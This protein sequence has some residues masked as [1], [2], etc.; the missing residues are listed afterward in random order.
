LCW[1]L[2]KG[3]A[4]VHL[5][6]YRV[7]LEADQFDQ[8]RRIL[9]RAGI[10]SPMT[11]QTLS[12]AVAATMSTYRSENVK[13]A[14]AMTFRE[15]HDSLRSL[16]RLAEEPDPPVGQIRALFRE[17][18]PEIRAEIEERAER[19]WPVYLGEPAPTNLTP[20]WLAD[21]PRDRLVAILPSA[22]S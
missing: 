13:H 10:A 2:N 4:V 22:I 6:P 14:G 9:K 8:I 5:E 18:P 11:A 19:R 12:E 20:G 21:L 16:W 15:K 1:L 3:F 7:A 17:L